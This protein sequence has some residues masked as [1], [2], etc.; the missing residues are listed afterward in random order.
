MD[1]ETF[2]LEQGYDTTSIGGA[3]FSFLLEEVLC[4]MNSGVSYK[5]IKRELKDIYSIYIYR[6]YRTNG[7]EFF[8]ELTSFLRSKSPNKR[9]GVG[10][11]DDNLIELAKK[12][13][14]VNEQDNVYVKQKRKTLSKSKNS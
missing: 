5:K 10:R 8:T 9:G 13:R 12:Y 6:F 3:M 1:C 11:V 7:H 2:L 14:V 4:M